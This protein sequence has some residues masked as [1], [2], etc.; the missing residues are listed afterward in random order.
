[1]K[2]VMSFVASALLTTVA[3]TSA[4]A[5]TQHAIAQPR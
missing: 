2:I 4:H 5:G 3:L 1:M